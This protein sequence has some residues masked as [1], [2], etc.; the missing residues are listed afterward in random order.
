MS[1]Q[2]T[3]LRC[4]YIVPFSSLS[5]SLPHLPPS[6]SLSPSLSRSSSLSFSIPI[7]RR[8][9]FFSFFLFFL[10]LLLYNIYFCCC[11][12]V[13]FFSLSLS[14]ILFTVLLFLLILFS[15]F[16][17]PFSYP[18][19]LYHLFFPPPSLPTP[20]GCCPLACH[21]PPF[22]IFSPPSLPHF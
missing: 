22:F 8:C 12:S 14:F 20:N 9:L 19:N 10:C 17:Y 5:P 7:S 18:G 11:V 13:F 21:P 1:P 15:S 16:F 6:L 3:A 4:S 2:S